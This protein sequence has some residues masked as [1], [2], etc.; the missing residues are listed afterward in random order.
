MR[1]SCGDSRTKNPFHTNPLGDQSPGKV[2]LGLRWFRES[3][4]RYVF[5]IEKSFL[6]S[7]GLGNLIK[8]LCE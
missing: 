1:K 4:K 8:Q 2:L 3:D 5:V 7:D 6:A